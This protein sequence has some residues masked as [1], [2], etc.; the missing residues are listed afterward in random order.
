MNRNS[1]DYFTYVLSFFPFTLFVVF[2]QLSGE[3]MRERLILSA[4]GLVPVLIGGYWAHDLLRSL[5]TKKML[6]IYAAFKRKKR[7]LIAVLSSLAAQVV[8]YLSLLVSNKVTIIAVV[9][10]PVIWVVVL[11]LEIVRA[12]SK[13]DRT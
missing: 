12:A 1:V 8:V 9:L 6:E 3:G 4:L 10:S 7:L 2:Y 11:L 5:L 13:V